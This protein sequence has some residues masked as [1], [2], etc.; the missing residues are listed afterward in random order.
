MIRL[1][2][3][4]LEAAVQ[5]QYNLTHAELSGLDLSG[6]KLSGAELC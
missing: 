6:A 2:R 3:P 1:T 4:L 5:A